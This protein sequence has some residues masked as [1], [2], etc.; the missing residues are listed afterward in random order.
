M[1]EP[2]T[3]VQF[4]TS[5]DGQI[6]SPG[7]TTM[8]GLQSLRSRADALRNSLNPA[9]RLKAEAQRRILEYLN[10]PSG[11][12]A[13]AAA[14]VSMTRAALS[15]SPR[16]MVEMFWS[17]LS[18]GVSAMSARQDI[19]DDV[20][21]AHAFGYWMFQHTNLPRPSRLPNLLLVEEE[22][23]DTNPNMPNVNGVMANELN[24]RWS[25][26]YREMM[27]DLNQRTPMSVIRNQ[28]QTTFG[29]AANMRGWDENQY[30]QYYR[31]LWAAEFQHDPRLAAS[32]F[33]LARIKNKPNQHRRL[34]T[35]MYRRCPYPSAG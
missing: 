3:N 5:P 22:T 32:T 23:E 33:L 12:F 1:S 4:F 30:R 13:D 20:C 31:I 6:R 16:A 11:Q 17:M 35:L 29:S 9:E 10:I 18:S 24:A 27:Q 15:G 19:R 26:C 25:R 7:Q 8:Q 14:I 34:T 28:V 21:A 2:D